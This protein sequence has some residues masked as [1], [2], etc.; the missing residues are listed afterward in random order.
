MNTLEELAA[1]EMKLL[2]QAGRVA[3]LMEDKFRQLGETGVFLESAAVHAAYVA[4][5]EPPASSLEALKRA[6]FLGWY[7]TAEPGCFTGIGELDPVRIRR[8]HELLDVAQAEGCIDP[9]FSVMLGWYW[10]IADYYFKALS[11]ARLTD[12]LLRLGPEAYKT[13][14]FTPASLEGRGQMGVYWISVACGAA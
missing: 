13:H 1:R 8:A 12:Y 3:G 10:F 2:E 9:E 11:P 14:P 7:A 5:A 6:I 4:L